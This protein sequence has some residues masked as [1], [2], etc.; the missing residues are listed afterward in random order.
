M[1]L[2]QRDILTSSFQHR[3]RDVSSRRALNCYPEFVGEMGK[4]PVVMV[5]T[6]GSET[7]IEITGEVG[8]VRGLHEAG[9]GR[10]FAFVG[11]GLYEIT[12]NQEDP[13]ESYSYTKLL[14]ISYV[15]GI[16]SSFQVSIADDGKHL[17]WVDGASYYAMS[18]ETNKLAPLELPE[19]LEQPKQVIYF[20]QRV[21]VIDNSNWFYW[22]NIRDGT[23]YTGERS[24]A[25]QSADPII[26]M[27]VGGD[28]LW[29]LGTKTYEVRQIGQDPNNP[30][31][32]ASVASEIGCHAPLS[33]ATIGDS[34]FWL[35]SSRA[36]ANLI[37]MSQ[38]VSSDVIS[39]QALHYFL[40]SKSD[41][42]R[43]AIAF[44]YQQEGHIFYVLT[45]RTSDKTFVYDVTTNLWH[46]RSTRELLTDIEHAW[47]YN[48]A[49]LGLNRVFV[50]SLTAPR[51]MILKMSKCDEWDSRPIKRIIQTGTIFDE[52]YELFYADLV[53][54]FP[55]GVSLQT[56][57]GDKAVLMMQYSD[58]GGITWGNLVKSEIG[59][60]GNYAKQVIFKRLGKSRERVF[61]FV[62]TDPIPFIVIGARVRI[63]RGLRP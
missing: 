29:L 35:G 63:K 48:T 6:A 3:S 30:F 24:S 15:P 55:A 38:G 12:R 62:M 54:D 7:A 59:Q 50:G 40:D 60:I 47:D 16:A 22:S 46:E 5:G 57:Q 17:I 2:I 31:P 42:T 34:V 23:K 51:L 10:F 45:L 11:G 1:P 53:V 41:E 13:E 19:D 4:S 61:R 39:D 8:I 9:N 21:V 44:T 43:D 52:Y 20:G 27:A 28:Y 33:V 32:F 26:R 36:G 56:G 37:F 49:C 18:Y 25:E 14:S 58:D